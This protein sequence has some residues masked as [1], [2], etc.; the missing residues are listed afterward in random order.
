MESPIFESF[1][2]DRSRSG[3]TDTCV[4]L[5]PEHNDGPDG[6][7]IGLLTS[8][9][10]TQLAFTVGGGPI[11]CIY[12]SASNLLY[13]VSGNELY[14][15]NTVGNVVIALG[16]LATTN[17]P[18]SM[19]ESPTQIF[20]VDGQGGYVWNFD[21]STFAQTIPNSTISAT[22]P[23]TVVT[24][25]GFALFNCLGTNLIYQSNYDDF[26]TYAVSNGAGL[27]AAANDA[28]VQGNQQPVVA[29]FDL[30][31][32]VW[33][34]K[35]NAT[36]VWANQGSGGFAFAP[37]QGIYMPFGCSAYASLARL[38]QSV[39][40]LGQSDEGDGVVYMSNGYNATPIT[41]YALA[42]QFQ[43]YNVN[44]DAVAYGCQQN[45]H[46]FYVLTFPAAN[47]TF[48]YDLTTGKWHQRGYFN[49]GNVGREIS[50]CCA[51]WNG[52]TYT[53]DYQN[54]NIY[55]LTEGVY[56]DNGSPRRWLRSWRA[57]PPTAPL[58]MPMSFD[59]LQV[60]LETGQTAP[61]GLVPEVM[62][63]W[64]DDGGYVW[65]GPFQ[66]N[67]GAIGQSSWRCILNRLGS[68]KI[69][70]GLDRCFEISGT[71]PMSIK[72]TGADVMAGPT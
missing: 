23:M 28:Y 69:G 40:W 71:D 36:E 55:L 32:Q 46:Y 72:I 18:V 39:C 13:V 54:S 22:N 25:D 47:L 51:L 16:S 29:M 21:T 1:F 2:Q 49:N 20:L 8:C 30:N 44:N 65:Q 50:N 59:S 10:G 42:R 34:F 37:L 63:R 33:I 61:E 45:G 3:N 26:S 64:S 17:G 4:N 9:P 6:P 58:G 70:T 5:Y 12:T 15:V 7:S 52:N 56:T 66:L 48:C 14:S 67:A 41:T 27:G 38:G 24:Q 53:G 68:T 60:L 11:R 35:Q 19:V 43:N 62:L 57:L 31:R